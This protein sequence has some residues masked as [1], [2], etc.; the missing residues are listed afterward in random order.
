MI[1]LLILIS[2]LYGLLFAN[3]QYLYEAHVANTDSLDVV[4]Q[5]NRMNSFFKDYRID[6]NA[7]NLYLFIDNNKTFRLFIYDGGDKVDLYQLPLTNNS[8]WHNLSDY[9]DKMRELERTVNRAQCRRSV[10]IDEFLINEIISL[11]LDSYPIVNF[12]KQ[13]DFSPYK[14]RYVPTNNKLYYCGYVKQNGTPKYFRFV[15]FRQDGLELRYPLN[16]F[17]VLFEKLE[18]YPFSFELETCK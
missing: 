12:K 6:W 10:S 15:D 4:T 9:M 1:L 13:N 5:K 16:K 11:K 2:I 14:Y 7:G 8:H 3:P 18:Q 17:I